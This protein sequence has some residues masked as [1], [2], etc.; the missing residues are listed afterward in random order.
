MKYRPGGAFDPHHDFYEDEQKDDGY[1]FGNRVAQAM[2]FLSDVELGGG[3]AMPELDIYINPRPGR[4]VVWHNLDQNGENDLRSL[5][6]G[7]PVFSGNK[8][9]AIT[10]YHHLNQKKWICKNETNMLN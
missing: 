3:F 9:A 8:L 1:D 6:G 2:I 7:C 5:H 10:S 4:M